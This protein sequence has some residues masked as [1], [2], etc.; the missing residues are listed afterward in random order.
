MKTLKSL[1]LIVALFSTFT[2]A[3]A[4]THD[5][6]PSLFSKKIKAALST[7]SS[8][9]SGSS[10]KITVYFV[11]DAEGKVTEANAKTTNKEA[12]QHIEKQ[13]MTLNLKGLTPC[14]TNTV[15]VHFVNY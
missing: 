7:P 14:V 8:L 15:D 4:G 2:T 1:L 9:K 12:K 10:E 13:F 6:G 11:V 5:K 3:L